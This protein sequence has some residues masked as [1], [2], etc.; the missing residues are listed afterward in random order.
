MTASN[1]TGY[2]AGAV[3][4]LLELRVGDLSGVGVGT[5]RV[6]SAVKD[7]GVVVDVAAGR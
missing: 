5:S 1:P 6:G 4:H 7:Y 2:G 3:R